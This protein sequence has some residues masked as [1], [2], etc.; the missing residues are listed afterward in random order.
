[1]SFL[2]LIHIHVGSTVEAAHA[3]QV[4]GPFPTREKAEAAGDK[5]YHTVAHI[6]T[7]HEN[8]FHTVVEVP[9]QPTSANIAAAML[10]DEWEDEDDEGV[11]E[12]VMSVQDLAAQFSNLLGGAITG[13]HPPQEQPSIED[14]VDHLAQQTGAQVEIIDE[15]DVPDLPSVASK[16]PQSVEEL[17]AMIAALDAKDE[18]DD[19]DEGDE[20]P[21]RDPKDVLGDGDFFGGSA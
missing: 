19:R 2:T 4:V 21:E 6:P 12:E 7:L 15:E 3:A 8:L 1:M 11:T 9:N 10:L 17:E 16:K 13:S 20:P 5:I 14:L 18:G